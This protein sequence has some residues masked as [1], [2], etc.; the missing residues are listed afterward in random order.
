MSDASTIP[1]NLAPLQVVHES[2]AG[3]GVNSQHPP[4]STTIRDNPPN[5]HRVTGDYLKPLRPLV[6][7]HFRGEGNLTKQFTIEGGSLAKTKRKQWTGKGAIAP[8][9]FN[10]PAAFADFLASGIEGCLVPGISPDGGAMAIGTAKNPIPSGKRRCKADLVYAPAF[11]ILIDYDHGDIED[12]AVLWQKILGILPEAKGAAWVASPSTSTWI[13]SP[14]GELVKGGGRWHLYIMANGGSDATGAMSNLRALLKGRDTGKLIDLSPLQQ[15]QPHYEAAP[16]LPPGYI[17]RKPAPVVSDGLLLDLEALPS[18]PSTERPKAPSS[19]AVSNRRALPFHLSPDHAAELALSGIDATTAKELGLCSVDGPTLR[20]YG[21]S[22]SLVADDGFHYLL[23]PYCDPWGE[24][25]RW[26]DDQGKPYPFARVKLPEGKRHGKQKYAQPKGSPT[27]AYIP[28]AIA[29]FHST[30]GLSKDGAEIGRSLPGD[31]LVTEGEKKA[32]AAT[33]S[34]RRCIGIGGVNC[35]RALW[36]QEFVLNCRTLTVFFDSDIWVKPLIQDALHSLGG[37]LWQVQ[38]YWFIK[39]NIV[40]VMDEEAAAD[41]D[42]HNGNTT[43]AAMLGELPHCYEI[44]W[45]KLTKSRFHFGLLPIG[46]EGAKM[47]LDD[48][49]QANC[50]PELRDKIL[51]TKLPL[52]IGDRVLF[53]I[54]GLWDAPPSKRHVTIEASGDDKT[55]YWD[56]MK[57]A[58]KGKDTK[59]GELR[60]ELHIRWPKYEARDLA[61]LLVVAS[62]DFDGLLTGDL[63]WRWQ[64]R[65]WQLASAVEVQNSY[66]KALAQYG[67]PDGNTGIDKLISR[68]ATTWLQGALPESDYIGLADCDLNTFDGS[69][70]PIHPSNFSRY[71]VAHSRKAGSHPRWDAALTELL[72]EDALPVFWSILRVGLASPKARGMMPFLPCII[73][74]PGSGKSAIMRVLSEGLGGLV[75]VQKVSDLY[76]SNANNG[77]IPLHWLGSR[78]IYDDDFKSQGKIPSEAIANLNKITTAADLTCR[79]MG[80]DPVVLPCPINMMILANKIPT[81]SGNDAEGF[82]RRFLP[83]VCQGEKR[84]NPN[85]NWHTEIIRDELPSIL[86]Y[87]F[88]ISIGT[89]LQWIDHHANSDG[90]QGVLGDVVRASHDDVADWVAAVWNANL[91]KSTPRYL[92]GWEAPSVVTLDDVVA[93]HLP[94]GAIGWLPAAE[95]HASYSRFCKISNAASLPKN[96]ANFS[97]AIIRLGG[98]RPDRSVL[99]FTKDEHS[100]IHK[101]QLAM[102]QLPPPPSPLTPD[103]VEG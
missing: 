77:F 39:S 71:R 58:P 1:L 48:Y 68:Q 70:R 76:A 91:R 102:V 60:N 92:D 22:G 44:G 101:Q 80:K 90:V 43:P 99:R 103:A 38:R 18:P 46:Y 20:R 17:Q 94:E 49:M 34:G 8:V 3:S 98:Q 50:N 82:H 16:L 61:A 73:G 30:F 7:G 4:D 33:M 12:P 100:G 86:D 84:A 69:S 65:I 2:H 32:I 29:D 78:L 88:S 24:P 83:L 95:A 97:E 23:F 26:E 15:S 52:T 35:Y 25:I 66:G 87:I 9:T 63:S 6:F 53:D 28:W 11:P 47:G 75:G 54:K 10:T 57:A 74:A 67:I 14:S 96:K 89:A 45:E 36:L 59:L 40:P 5:P 42:L 62:L 21:F 85:P 27:I 37:W 51:G 19:V 55:W 81:V 79:A 41:W 93:R 56:G 72:G 64:D 13:Y 31:F